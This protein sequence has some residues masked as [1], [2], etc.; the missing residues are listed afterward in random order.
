MCLMCWQRLLGHWLPIDNPGVLRSTCCHGDDFRR[1]VESV[2]GPSGVDFEDT[3]RGNRLKSLPGPEVWL[4]IGGFSKWAEIEGKT[5]R[6]YVHYRNTNDP[7]RGAGNI[8]EP[9]NV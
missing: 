4:A 8:A 2:P 1:G 3:G 9:A 6:F 5:L 7:R